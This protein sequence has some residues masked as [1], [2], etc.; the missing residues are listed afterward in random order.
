MPVFCDGFPIFSWLE[1]TDVEFLGPL[2]LSVNVFSW[3]D[4]AEFL[5]PLGLLVGNMRGVFECALLRSVA[6]SSVLCDE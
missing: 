1:K 5:T 4:S 3:S 6:T 2:E